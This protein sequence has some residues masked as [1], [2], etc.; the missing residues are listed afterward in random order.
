MK[1]S[2]NLNLTI[3]T[4]TSVDKIFCRRMDYLTLWLQFVFCF[5]LL[6]RLLHFS[7]LCINWTRYHLLLWFLFTRHKSLPLTIINFALNLIIIPIGLNLH[8]HFGFTDT[9]FILFRLV[10]LPPVQPTLFILFGLNSFP[11]LFW[12]LS[13]LGFH[14]EFLFTSDYSSPCMSLPTTTFT[15]ESQFR[16]ERL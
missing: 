12:T 4:K 1:L 2:K 15:V 9:P 8:I 13:Y 3:F 10:G 7:L 11:L 5:K 6:S 16:Q 14:L